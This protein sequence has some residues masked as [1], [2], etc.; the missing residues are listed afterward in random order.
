M[1]GKE[2]NNYGFLGNLRN[3]VTRPNL[4]LLF[5]FS[6]RHDKSNSQF[7]LLVSCVITERMWHD[8]VT[9]RPALRAFLIALLLTCRREQSRENSKEVVLLGEKPGHK[10]IRE[11]RWRT[12]IFNH[13]A[14]YYTTDLHPPYPLQEITKRLEKKKKTYLLHVCHNPKEDVLTGNVPDPSVGS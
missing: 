7:H 10:I 12:L 3:Q 8:S 11:K 6:P 5:L 2:N 13:I 9:Q 4:S 1:Q 14:L